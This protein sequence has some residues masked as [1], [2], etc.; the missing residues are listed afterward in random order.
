MTAPEA[1]PALPLDPHK[2]QDRHRDRLAIV[3][4]RQSTPQQVVEHRESAAL[5]YQLRQ[6]AVELGWP[7]S[8]VLVIDDDQG[9]SGQ[10]IEG[11]PGF[12]RLLA[13]VGLDHVGIVFG[14]EMSRLARS[15]K[16]WHQLLELCGLFQT[17]L[18][19]QDGVYDP[20]DFNDR[21]LLGLKGTMSEAETHIL[22]LRLNQGRLN[23]ARRGELFSVAPVGYVRAATGELQL[24]PDEQVRSA[25]RAVFEK[26][27]ELGSAAAV[28]AYLIR[29]DI[30]LGVR[31]FRG[32]R[33]GQLV[34]QKPRRAALYEMLRHPVY[35]GAY[36]YGR[37]RIDPRRRVAGRH[38]SGRYWAP[39]GEWACLIRDRLPAYI[40]WDQYEANLRRLAEND[41][42]WWARRGPRRSTTVLNGLLF[43]G[44]CGR[45]MSVY[46]SHV[47]H[48][49]RYQCAY[50]KT[51]LGEPLCQ[52][53]QAE[54]VDDL[55]VGQ[56]LHALEPAALELSLQ[57][58]DRVEQ[59]RDRLHRHW[60]Q[61]RE[62]AA[63]EAERAAR[64]FDAVD[65]G[66]RLVARTLERQWEERLA[67]QQRLEE[68]HARFLHEQPRRLTDGDRER[69]RALA[70]DMPTL[71]HA[72]GTGVADRR[73][74]VRQLIERVELTQRVGT[75][76]LDVV[77]RWR[78]GMASRHEVA[79]RVHR[80]EQLRDHR[81]LG[82]RVAALRGEGRTG[83][84]IA[85]ALN[86]EGYRAPRGAAFTKHIVSRL[87]AKLGLIG[88]PAGVRGAEDLPGADEWWLGDLADRLGATRNALHR[89]R[90]Q[91]WVRG[92]Q[93]PG[94]QGR[95]ILWADRDELVRLGRLRGFLSKHPREPMPKRLM[96]PKRRAAA[97]CPANRKQRSGRASKGKN[98]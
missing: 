7:P 17:L 43:C 95:W 39:R 24:D 62:R 96:T 70:A 53:V 76:W 37:R 97:S 32:P 50:A 58:A 59:E 48:R 67:A 77:I 56:L 45:R 27:E 15:N 9:C 25:V 1:P 51:E 73:G 13:E 90:R 8:R 87:F 12:Q 36:A 71:W 93:L 26:F 80:Y 22:K 86:R 34:W 20:G 78:G 18:A 6:R 88:M 84:E 31:P 69:I 23:K 57:A 81:A 75:E 35:A 28:H 91:G 92:R 74:V 52:G 40:G 44:R 30:R 49:G 98:G 63:Y 5:Q 61:R 47:E 38:G 94:E 29:H 72:A 55:V 54:T 2:V 19:D 46:Y 64:Q 65:P 82:Q 21:L 85:E 68:D 16:D 14:R 66:N 89:W 79:R 83:R 60:K 41:Q 4:V 10:S 33:R 42:W 3:Y 11:R